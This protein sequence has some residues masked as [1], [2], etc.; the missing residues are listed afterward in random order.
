MSEIE[1][2]QA[3]VSS[4]HRHLHHHLLHRGAD[5]AGSQAGLVGILREDQEEVAVA[6]D[7][8]DARAVGCCLLRQQTHELFGII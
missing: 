6:D 2:S 1:I 5:A 3:Y 8:V 7:R 4:F